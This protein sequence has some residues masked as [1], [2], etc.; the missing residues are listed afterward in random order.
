MK[1][2][3]RRFGV[4]ASAALV[5][6]LVGLLVAA[7]GAGVGFY[8]GSGFGGFGGGFSTPPPSGPRLLQIKVND[9]EIFNDRYS[10][11]AEVRAGATTFDVHTSTNP[12]YT[13][14]LVQMPE[15]ISISS[16]IEG[17]MKISNGGTED[18]VEAAKFDHVNF[19]GARIDADCPVRFTVVLEPGT[20]YLLAFRGAGVSD[21]NPKAQK[22]IVS[23]TA[24]DTTLPETDGEIVIADG[25]NGP[26][27]TAP[28][29]WPAEGTFLVRN[30]AAYANEAVFL[31]LKPGTTESTLKQFFVDSP[32][33]NWAKSP[34]T[35]LRVC[36]LAPMSQGRQAIVHF[37][38]PSGPY[39][40][41]SFTFNRA[42]NKRQYQLG[43]FQLLTL[44][45]APEAR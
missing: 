19:G 26:R 39:V 38:S 1:F 4:R 12:G 14:L 42:A 31:P 11:T 27:F 40:L 18:P 29:S 25:P 34:I 23:G 33:P 17:L 7:A 21:P 41:T 43:A 13:V 45:S 2:N 30:E 32:R 9:Q 44:S 28:D 6:G 8:L 20:Y 5:L 16:Y 15:G 22:V 37:N 24:S 36:G 3:V 10:Q 35:T